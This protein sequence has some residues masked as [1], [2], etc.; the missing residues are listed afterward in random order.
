MSYVAK[1]GR[2]RLTFPL[3]PSNAQLSEIRKQIADYTQMPPSSFKLVHAGAVMKDDNA[4]ISAYG[5]NEKS[6]IAI[7]GGGDN[8][9]PSK[10]S[11][12]ERRTEESTVKQIRSELDKVRQMLQPDVDT[13]LSTLQGTTTSSAPTPPADTPLVANGKASPAKEINLAQE[14]VRLG[15]ML[16]QSLLRLDAII[17]EGEWEEARR[18]RK[19]AVKEVQGLLDRLDGAWRQRLK[20]S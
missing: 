16:L 6:K 5:I 10:K 3:P 19:S 15:E 2:E 14:H 8:S 11:A 9:L 13:F 18:E 7:V 1:W 12:P 20:S 17:A 4:P